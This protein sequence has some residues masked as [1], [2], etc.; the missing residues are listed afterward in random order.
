MSDFQIH[1]DSSS[2]AERRSRRRQKK[3]MVIM[4]AAGAVLLFLVLI[5]AAALYSGEAPPANPVAPAPAVA[6]NPSMP[7]VGTEPPAVDT[8]V[9]S[10]ATVAPTPAAPVIDDDG[11]TMWVSPTDGPALDLRGLPQGCEMF[12]ALRP[13]ELLATSEGQKMI[14]A[15]GPRGENGRKYL[16]QTIGLPLDDVAELII[17]LRPTASAT[18]ESALVVTM[19][20]G[21]T[22]SARGLPIGGDQ[23]RVAFASPAMLEEIQDL[24]GTAPPLR[25]EIESL[26]ATTDGSRQVTV[27]VAP[28]FLFQ[29]GR[30]M[31]AASLAPLRDTLFALIPDSTRGVALSFNADEQFFAELRLVATIDQ[32]PEAFAKVFADKISEW[33]AI[34]ER[35]IAT[36]PASPHSATVVARLPSMLRTLTRYQRVGFE[37]DQALLRVYL[38]D[39]AGHNLL[40]AA[41]LLLAEQTSGGAPAATPVSAANPSNEPATPQGG[42]AKVT[43]LSFAR[44]TLETAVQLLAEDTGVD[45]VL[46]GG[47]L[48]LDGITKNQSFALNESNKPASDILVAILRLANPDKT[49]T[50]PTD[51]KQKLVYV[52]GANP[53]TGEPAILVT[54]RSQ[55]EK[56]GDALP[57]IFTE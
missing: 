22:T 28:T 1:T 43:S 26:L 14:A 46:M 25:R 38:P 30:A 29:D 10:R 37:G 50:G 34:T 18:I 12:V 56:R 31:W 16:E 51:P 53:A 19:L 54:T 3:Q 20:P 42:L 24:N 32:R 5:V 39:V 49:A 13:A 6:A 23:G 21:T 9:A 45:I 48:Q 2:L 52:E 33:P 57:A 11:R 41:E 27:L 36:V 15:L 8:P 55:A 47:D 7:G 44:D 40:M 17:G 35:A 4:G